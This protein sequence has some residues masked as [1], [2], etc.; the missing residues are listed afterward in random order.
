MKKKPKNKQQT[1]KTQPK[2]PTQNAPLK[3]ENGTKC[4][5][6]RDLS[7]GKQRKFLFPIKWKNSNYFEVDT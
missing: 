3:Q 2:K 5:T 7:E 6:Q 1:K 4:N